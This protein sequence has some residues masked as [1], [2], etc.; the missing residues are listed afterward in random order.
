MS[1]DLDHFSCYVQNC[2]MY[3]NLQYFINSCFCVLVTGI[4]PP[5]LRPQSTAL[6]PEGKCSVNTHWGHIKPLC[7]WDVCQHCHIH[8]DVLLDHTLEH[9]QGHILQKYKKQT[10]FSFLVLCAS[11]PLFISCGTVLFRG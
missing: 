4:Y 3:S 6:H 7:R 2:V 5:D 8:R 11:P 1:H 9:V 10:F